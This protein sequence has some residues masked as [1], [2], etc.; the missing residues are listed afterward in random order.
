[1]A[2]WKVGLGFGGPIEDEKV[3]YK[4]LERE[5]KIKEKQEMKRER[6]E[7]RKREEIL[8]GKDPKGKG[9]GVGLLGS[10]RRR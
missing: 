5:M 9:K 1:M 4:R 8:W 10:A 2:L 7:R 6:E 3:E